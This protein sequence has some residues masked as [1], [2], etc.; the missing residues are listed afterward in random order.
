MLRPGHFARDDLSGMSVSAAR[1]IV[2]RAQ[3]RMEMLDKLGKVGNRPAAEI[4]RDKR[5]VGTFAKEV[6]DGIHK[7]LVSDNAS[8]RLSEMEKH[9]RT[10]RWRKTTPPSGASTSHWRNMVKRPPNG[11]DDCC[12]LRTLR[13]S[14]AR[15]LG[16]QIAHLA[17]QRIVLDHRRGRWR[18][19]VKRRFGWICALNR[20]HNANSSSLRRDGR[21]IEAKVR[22]Y[23]AVIS[24]D[25]QPFGNVRPP[26]WARGARREARGAP[27]ARGATR[28]G[29]R[30]WHSA[31]A[32]VGGR[33]RNRLRNRLRKT[34]A[35]RDPG[36]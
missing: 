12:R 1:E 34:R 31:S 18:H 25:S 22:D 7:M 16:L 26:G 23:I 11:A 15:P 27:S 29:A 9:Y 17:G 13:P 24:A 35:R 28:D 30:A 21:R 4:A 5:H 20:V 36:G 32:S 19:H 3:S 10:R 6:A 2:E 33:L 8:V 14:I